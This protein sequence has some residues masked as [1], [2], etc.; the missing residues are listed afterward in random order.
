MHNEYLETYFNQYIGLSDNK[1]SKLGN[2]FD[3]VNL[4]LVDVYNTIVDVLLDGWFKNE[5]S[6]NTTSKRDKKE[7]AGLSDMPQLEGD[8]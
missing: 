6:P 2:K 3:P 8:E 1:K 5:E 4:F 7:S